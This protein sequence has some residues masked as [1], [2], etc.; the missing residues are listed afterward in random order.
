MRTVKIAE[1]KNNLSRHLA[2]VKR[3][4]TVRILDRDTPVADLVPIERVPAGPGDDDA[5]LASLEERGVIRRGTPGALPGDRIR[6][7][8]ADREGRLM[9]ALLEERRGS[10]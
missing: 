10:R 2:Y 7:G 3:G 9:S 1:A 5:L 4:G 8:P 6:P